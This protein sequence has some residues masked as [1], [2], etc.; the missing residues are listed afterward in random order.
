[1]S[2]KKMHCFVLSTHITQF[3]HKYEAGLKT[4]KQVAQ[5]LCVR[6][7]MTNCTVVQS[8]RKAKSA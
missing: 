7:D 2:R 6:V 5:I 4:R 8:S 3:I 1:M